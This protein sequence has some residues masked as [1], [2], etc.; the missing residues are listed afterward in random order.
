MNIQ[1]LRKADPARSWSEIPE[2]CP[3]NFV[4]IICEKRATSI[5]TGQPI[6][7]PP[8]FGQR[9]TMLATS[10]VDLL[11]P[12]K[13]E[14]CFEDILGLPIVKAVKRSFQ[15]RP[16]TLQER[17]DRQ[18]AEIHFERCKSAASLRVQQDSK[19]RTVVVPITQEEH[20]RNLRSRLERLGR[21]IRRDELRAELA[22]F[23]QGV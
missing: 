20:D 1:E 13:R 6:P 16:E 17:A 5:A 22:E 8:S 2:S 7:T 10:F 14:I 19:G 23:K 15:R 21:E 9:V 18:A 11:T 4:A 12:S 3:A